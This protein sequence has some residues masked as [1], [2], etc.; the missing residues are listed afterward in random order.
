MAVSDG[1]EPSGGERH[2]MRDMNGSP[3]RE[4]DQIA[5]GW[6]D[7]GRDDVL[8]LLEMA[9]DADGVA[10]TDELLDALLLTDTVTPPGGLSDAVLQRALQQ[11]SAGPA[12]GPAPRQVSALQ[13]FRETADDLDRLLVSLRPEEW[14]RPSPAYGDVR[15]IVAHLVGI[16]RLAL[17]WFGVLPLPAADVAADHLAASRDAIVELSTADPAS[18]RSTWRQLVIQ[19]GDAATAAPGD[20]TVMAHDIPVGPDGAMLLRA[21]ELWTHH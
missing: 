11:R 18:L 3:G 12:S 16:E 6:F 17:G 10:A 13:A 9:Q 4:P 7:D 14:S 15:T 21:F 20:L 1:S 8:A 2:A 19:V 5:E